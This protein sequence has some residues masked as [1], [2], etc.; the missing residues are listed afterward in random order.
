MKPL[1]VITSRDNVA[2]AL[3]RLEAGQPLT[4]GERALSPR[5]VIPSGHKMAFAEIA[6]GAAV[7]KYGA[8][9]GIATREIHAGDHV[10]THNVA[11]TRGRGD[12]RTAHD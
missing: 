12:L 8:P 7:I 6:Q 9:I 10:H 3:M 2:T 5:E 1:L 11:S 4:V